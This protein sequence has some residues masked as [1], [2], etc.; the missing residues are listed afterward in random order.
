MPYS[1]N[2]AFFLMKT[3]PLKRLALAFAGLLAFAS[4]AN[5]AIQLDFVYDTSTGRTTASYNGTWDVNSAGSPGYENTLYGDD[6]SLLAIQGSFSVSGV[7]AF[8]SQ[9]AWDTSFAAQGGSGDSFGFNTDSIN[10]TIFGPAGFT[11]S[12]VMSGSVY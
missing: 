1:P 10:A 2:P 7:G 9:F 6:Y 12:T 8:S 11:S 5:A 3:S 4:A